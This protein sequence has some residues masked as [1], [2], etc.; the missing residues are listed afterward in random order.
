MLILKR[1]KQLFEGKIYVWNL[2]SDNPSQNERER[3]RT[4]KYGKI[5]I[6]ID[7][8]W[9][10]YEHS[11]YYSL[12]FLLFEIFHNKEGQKER[13]SQKNQAFYSNTWHS[14]CICKPVS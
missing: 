1:W 12:N 2:L 8:R 14:D 6:T 10:A 13:L 4:N 7:F 9:W 5:L 11:F 3:E